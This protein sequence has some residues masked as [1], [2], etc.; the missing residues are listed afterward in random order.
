MNKG[1]KETNQK[2]DS[3]IENRQLPEGR[4][5]G[6]LEI[7]EV[8]WEHSYHEHCVIHGIVK[9]LHCVPETNK[10]LYANYTGIKVKKKENVLIS[11]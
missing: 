4:W 11:F 2:I 6:I 1:K 3:T 9:S 7:N 8:D 5:V 10:T